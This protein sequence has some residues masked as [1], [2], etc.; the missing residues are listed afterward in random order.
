MKP[1]KLLPLLAIACVLLFFSCKKDDLPSPLSVEEASEELTTTNNEF[2]SQMITHE[3]S[4]GLTTLD[5]ASKI[6]IDF[7]IPLK[8]TIFNNNILTDIKGSEYE[9]EP[10]YIEFDFESKKGTWTYNATS[11]I[12]DHNT[13]SPTDKVVIKFSINEG[14][15]SYTL[16][17][18][19][20]INDTY[21]DEKTSIPYI[22][23]IK[24]QIDKEGQ[25]NPVI[26]WEYTASRTASSGNT[27]HVYTHDGFIKTI[28]NV[29]SKSISTSTATDTYNCST[30]LE[31]GGKI[32]TANST[33]GVV[34]RPNIEKNN[35]FS[36]S[37]EAKIRVMNVVLLIDNKRDQNTNI[38]D[39]NTYI[40][41][42]VEKPNGAKVCKII[43]KS[44]EGK[45]E[46]YFEF[47][48]GSQKSIVEYFSKP[49]YSQVFNF[50]S[51]LEYLGARE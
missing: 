42:A 27:K 43:Y 9:F 11:L 32:I 21:D 45:Y 46:P 5:A 16:T 18:S 38:E 17:Y 20:F 30:K 29:I 6:N 3:N 33:K 39:P 41:I 7:S 22:K 24:A 34:T 1:K 23:Q 14:I 10:R 36:V 31:K 15:D 40:T 19:D 4:D 50:I 28:N 51:S 48:D 26:T 25:V 35:E 44:V 49:L 47:N 12:W 37:I 8:T 13:T 2:I